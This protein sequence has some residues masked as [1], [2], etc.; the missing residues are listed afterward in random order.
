MNEFCL[1]DMQAFYLEKLVL[2]LK[3]IFPCLRVNITL[4]SFHLRD[5]I[6]PALQDCPRFPDI[7]LFS[8]SQRSE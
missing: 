4:D 6:T 3:M 5:K 2:L 8:D 7:T 1:S